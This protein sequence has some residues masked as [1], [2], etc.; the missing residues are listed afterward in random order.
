[1]SVALL[2]KAAT[3][4]RERAGA[5]TPGGWVSFGNNM[6][7][8]VDRCTCSPIH[9]PYEM[10]ENFCGLEGPIIQA[11]DADISYIATMH[12]GVGLALADVLEHLAIDRENGDVDGH[13][14]DH[15]LLPLVRLIV[16][17]RP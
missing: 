12:P 5:A 8:T 9:D 17:D 3:I 4:L 1:M 6:A 7:A 13:T 11:C 2:R 16:G 10:H 15:G 14:W